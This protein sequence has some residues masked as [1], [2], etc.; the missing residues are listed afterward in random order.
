MSELAE[1]EATLKRDGRYAW[2]L[3]GRQ[4][5]SVAEIATEYS[6]ATGVPVSHDTVTRWMRR[7]G[8]GAENYGGTIGWRVQR[9]ALVLFFA[10]GKHLRQNPGDE[11]EAG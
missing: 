10:A 2:L 7:I 3:S 4:A 9:D 11:S 6:A 5:W 8:E 1:A